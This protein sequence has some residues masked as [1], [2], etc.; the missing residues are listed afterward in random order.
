MT[1]KHGTTPQVNLDAL[2]GLCLPQ[3]RFAVHDEAIRAPIPA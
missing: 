1:M 2:H 3:L